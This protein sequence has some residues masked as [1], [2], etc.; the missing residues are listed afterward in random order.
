[1]WNSAVLPPISGSRLPQMTLTS[2]RRAS[3]CSSADNT[4]ASSA[5]SMLPASSARTGWDRLSCIPPQ[6]GPLNLTRT[7]ASSRVSSVAGPSS[8][9]AN[10]NANFSSVSTTTSLR[11]PLVTAFMKHLAPQHVLDR[12]PDHFRREGLVNETDALALQPID[13]G[14]AALGGDDDRSDRFQVGIGLHVFDHFLTRHHRHV[15]VG[16]D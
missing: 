2:S 8:G 3:C 5:P 11:M 16:D 4:E 14:L 12:V 1:M 9:T 6:I 13:A 15:D 10:R 7:V